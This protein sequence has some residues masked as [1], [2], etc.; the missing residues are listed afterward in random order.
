MRAADH[1]TSAFESGGSFNKKWAAVLAVVFVA[2]VCANYLITYKV[3]SIHLGLAAALALAV[4]AAYKI[5][6]LHVD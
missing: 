5:I 4:F 6:D 2:A 1:L 3:F